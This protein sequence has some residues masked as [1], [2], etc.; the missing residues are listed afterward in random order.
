MHKVGTSET[1]LGR[2]ITQRSVDRRCIFTFIYAKRA[3]IS[4][5]IP[6]SGASAL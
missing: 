3:P 4:R 5:D 1:A 6:G 2:L